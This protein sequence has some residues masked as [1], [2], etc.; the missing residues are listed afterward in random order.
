[1][2]RKLI[3][4]LMF[5]I[6]LVMAGCGDG[7]D[8]DQELVFL[9][10]WCFINMEY[11]ETGDQTLPPLFYFQNQ[12]LFSLPG[13]QYFTLLDEALRR[14]PFAPESGVGTMINDRI[15]FHSVEVRNG[16]AYVDM[17]GAGLS[18]SSL[19]EGLL[20]SQI[21]SSLIGS[22]E[23]IDRVQFLIDGEVSDSL[24]GHYDTAYPFEEGIHPTGVQQ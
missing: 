20:I 9:V 12:T 24:M 6:M 15:Q 19:E 1:M 4:L 11:V 3:V 18:G 17:V 22:F 5:T 8:P 14:V 2:K 10:D 7:I 16:T 23:E 21:V 13:K